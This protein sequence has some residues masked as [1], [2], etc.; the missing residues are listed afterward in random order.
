MELKTPLLSLSGIGPSLADRLHRLNLF[1]VEDLIYHFPF[2]YDDFSATQ[3]LDQ[4]RIG[5]TA[6]FR[7]ELWS[8]KNTYTRF[9]KVLTQAILND[10]TGTVEIIWFNQPWLIKNLKAGDRLQVSGKIAKY[11]S[12]LSIIAPRWEKLDTEKQLPTR[13]VGTRNVKCPCVFLI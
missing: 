11:K 2:R 10:G 8:I 1:T 5:E 7:G 4:T 12:K 9:R 3:N 13:Q 6:T